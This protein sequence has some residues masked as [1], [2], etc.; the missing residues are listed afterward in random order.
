MMCMCM[1]EQ[2]LPVSM[3]SST[4]FPS[5]PPP[6][7][8]QSYGGHYIVTGARAILDSNAAGNP[9]LNLAGFAV[10]NAWTVAEIDNTGCVEMWLGHGLISQETH[11]G[12]LA[13]CN[14]SDIGPLSVT[15]QAHL[16]NEEGEMVD[17]AAAGYGVLGWRGL[18]GA[19]SPGAPSCDDWQNEAFGSLGSIDIYDEFVATCAATPE[20]AG[21]AAHGG[22]FAALRAAARLRGSLPPARAAPPLV[23][24]PLAAPP[25][26]SNVAAGCAADY[27][28]CAEN[29]IK[30]YLNRPEV[31]AALH[32]VPELIPGGSWVG[33]S[34]IIS[35]SRFDLLTSML[36]VYRDVLTRLP[37][38]RFLV[39]SGDVD[40]I[41]PFTG[42]RV[43]IDALDLVTT[44]KLHP[45]IAS[46][47]DVGGW[48]R[49]LVAP[50]AQ[51]A[52][53]V[54]ASVR[55]AGHMVPQTQAARGLD[56]LT[57]FLSGSPF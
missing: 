48:T 37:A 32:V 15:F 36:P 19:A 14:M 10:G 34:S 25:A 33:C 50:W 21:A 40:L 41:V 3:A 22:S 2:R 42:T 17:L 53:L 12:L 45:W 57:T 9:R 8:H 38:G 54:F 28:P 26:D 56:L 29:K 55:N 24:R 27:D 4:H 16:H 52:T 35:Y 44:S 20:G 1:G 31:Q 18:P 13:S 51:N 49:T 30:A 5:F 39:F 47:G 43:W 23:A 7:M 11:D 6:T 46:A